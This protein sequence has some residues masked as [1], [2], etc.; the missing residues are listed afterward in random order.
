MPYLTV[1]MRCTKCIEVYVFF[2]HFPQYITVFI[3]KYWYEILYLKVNLL[4]NELLFA[5]YN[6]V[7]DTVFQQKWRR[8]CHQRGKNRIN[9]VRYFITIAV[10]RCL[11]GRAGN[12][13]NW[14]VNFDCLNTTLTPTWAIYSLIVL[15][16]NNM[17]Q[18]LDVKWIQSSSPDC[19]N[20]K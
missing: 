5:F 10:V 15:Y 7:T 2:F 14:Y 19:K 13:M 16:E 20:S 6:I 1:S 18:Y 3:I 12:F 17:R 11:P 9:L 8:K 4:N